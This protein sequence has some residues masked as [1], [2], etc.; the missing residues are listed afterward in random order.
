ME[1]Y[2]VHQGR[3]FFFKTFHLKQGNTTTKM[4][5]VKKIKIILKR[6]SNF[7]VCAFPTFASSGYGNKLH[8]A[9]RLMI[10]RFGGFKKCRTTS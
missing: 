4:Q 9:V 8:M 2:C 10:G 7:V 3:Y 5:G 6:E 1:A